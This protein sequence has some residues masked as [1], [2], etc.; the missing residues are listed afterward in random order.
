[1]PEKRKEL[2]EIDREKIK[3][4]EEILREKYKVDFNKRNQSIREKSIYIKNNPE[5]ILEANNV[6]L[7]KVK[8]DKWY[9][10]IINKILSI[11]KF[12]K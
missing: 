2:L 9:K 11:F 8:K 7:E 12:K 10:T 5:K 6:Y 3:E 1:M 4:K